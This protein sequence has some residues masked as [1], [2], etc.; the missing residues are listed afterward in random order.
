MQVIGQGQFIGSLCRSMPQSLNLFVLHCRM[1][2]LVNIGRSELDA[3]KMQ[4]C[5]NLARLTPV[6]EALFRARWQD[7]PR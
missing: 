4:A 6:V 7:P 3:C 2:A 1:D 5:H